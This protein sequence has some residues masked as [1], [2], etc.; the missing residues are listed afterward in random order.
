M[1]FGFSILATFRGP[2][3]L[4]PKTVCRIW[5]GCFPAV[6]ILRKTASGDG[7]ALI[8]KLKTQPKRCRPA[9]FEAVPDVGLQD[10]RSGL[11]TSPPFAEEGPSCAQACVESVPGRT[12][13]DGLLEALNIAE[14]ESN[15]QRAPEPA[16]TCRTKTSACPRR[17]NSRMEIHSGFRRTGCE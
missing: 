12:R 9:F 8:N 2:I 11:S 3:R 4:R 17:C 6:R 7:F 10:P 14:S 5:A 15:R 1:I 13:A 16:K